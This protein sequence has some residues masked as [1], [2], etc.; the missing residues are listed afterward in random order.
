MY[1]YC[2]H[3]LSCM[4]LD[5]YLAQRNSL[6]SYCMS[7]PR[8]LYMIEKA[9]YQNTSQHIQLQS[10]HTSTHYSLDL[11]NWRII[12]LNNQVHSPAVWPATSCHVLVHLLNLVES[13][14]ELARSK[15]GISSS[16]MGFY[17]SSCSTFELFVVLLLLNQDIQTALT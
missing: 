15:G 10:L 17:R 1:T 9:D 13:V 14:D 8:N 6:C 16:S 5:I 2:T 11:N 12:H 7:F 4:Q 3:N